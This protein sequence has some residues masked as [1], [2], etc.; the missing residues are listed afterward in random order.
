MNTVETKEEELTEAQKERFRTIQQVLKINIDGDW[1]D[2]MIQKAFEYL[3]KL[4]DGE[5]I[6]GGQVSS[7]KSGRSRGRAP[8]KRK[9]PK[10]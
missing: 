1:D 9:S 8:A 5:E 2:T 10:T 6:D 7:S 3:E 4:M